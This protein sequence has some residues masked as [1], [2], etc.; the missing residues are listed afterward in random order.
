MHMHTYIFIASQR[1][2]IDVHFPNM[3]IIAAQICILMATKNTYM[4]VACSFAAF[5][6]SYAPVN[7]QYT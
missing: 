1:P 5:G 3:E 6:G 4:V 2:L 7:T